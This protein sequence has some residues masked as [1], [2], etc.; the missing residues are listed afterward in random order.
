MVKNTYSIE[1]IPLERTNEFFSLQMKYLIDDKIITDKEDIEYF[2]SEEYRGIIRAHM[3]REIDKHHMV[4]ILRNGKRIGAA[5]F[6]TYQSKD[7]ECFVLDF[8][9]FP[10][11]RGNGTGHNAFYILEEYTKKDGALY[12]RINAEKEDSIKFWKSLG[13]IEDGFDEYDMPLFIKR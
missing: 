3:A 9:V 4:Y 7:G 2:E 10:P 8:W 6:N 11:Y 13:F 1:E 12:Y 5:Q